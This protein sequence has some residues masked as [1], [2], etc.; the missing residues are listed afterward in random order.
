VHLAHFLLRSAVRH[1]DRPLWITPDRTISYREGASR[2]S[3]LARSLLDRVEPGDRVA[4]LMPNRFEGMETFQACASVGLAAVPMNA[5]LHPD[6]HAFML[7]DSGAR[8]LVYDETFGEHV[9]KVREQLETVEHWICV[10]AGAGGDTPYESLFDR[11]DDSPVDPVIDLDDT[12]W[13]FYTSGTTGKPKGA[14]ETHR[15]LIT[16]TQ[17]FL[18]GVVPD[19][20]PTDVFL[21]AAPITHGTNSCGFPHLA[22]GAAHAFLERFD[23]A[24][25]FRAVQRLRV[26]TTFLV[27][28]MINMLLPDPDRSE[29]D[30]SSLRT[31]IYGGG[32]MYF[33]QLKASMGAFGKIFVQVFGQGEAPM[34]ITALPKE[35][36]M[37][38]GGDRERRLGSAGRELP[39]VRVGIVDEQDR[40]EPP[41]RMG[42]I[43]VRGDLVMRGYWNRPEANAETLK[44]G[45]LHTGD[46][47][48]LD[49]EG[50]L[51]ITDRKKDLIISGG[52]NIYPREVEEVILQHPAVYEV[53]VIGVPDETWG[54][55]VMALVALREGSPAT[56]D[57][58]VEHCRQHLASYKKPR[59]V[60]FV[61]S[62]PKS[63]YGKILKRELRE[64]YWAGRDRR[65]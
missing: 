54:E 36:H 11:P 39:A 44:G 25:F 4:Y 29:H 20:R 1:P 41:G 61:P 13:L 18:L 34:T 3:R 31:V 2:V 51:F 30:L 5:R 28:T 7:Q 57:E 6:E 56:E 19:A 14:M 37:L 53:A 60:R 27:P 22:V 55:T 9:G 38:D 49:E 48:Y 52:A 12:A 26:T 63:G 33:E 10:G 15:N 65:V 62:L 45:W 17:Q 16:M 35:E 21:H 58:I 40:P 47:G 32:P 64:E 50:Y 43:A 8:A 46:V 23:P 42:E 59:E 24:G